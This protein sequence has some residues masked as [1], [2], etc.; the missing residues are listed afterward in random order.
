[1]TSQVESLLSDILDQP[2]ATLMEFDSFLIGEGAKQ[3]MDK[4]NNKCDSKIFQISGINTVEDLVDYS[5]PTT[6]TI[7]MQNDLATFAGQEINY[8]GSF[9]TLFFET[10]KSVLEQFGYI[11]NKS[12]Q[13]VGKPFREK[14]LVLTKDDKY[15]LS[16]LFDKGLFNYFVINSLG[17]LLALREMGFTE[18]K[19]ISVDNCAICQAMNGTIH[20][21]DTLVDTYNSGEFFIH[22]NLLCKFYPVIR[23]RSAYDGLANINIKSIKAESKTLINVPAEFEQDVSDLASFLNDI[24]KVEFADISKVSGKGTLAVKTGKTLFI[25]CDYVGVYSPMDYLNAWVDQEANAE[26]L[27]S[28]INDRITSEDVYYLNGK[29][30]VEVNGLYYDIVSKQIVR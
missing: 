24:D 21:V 9:E 12:K 20:K 23:K 3:F 19:F 1:M 26:K 4:C 25:H 28:T 27:L 13:L 10:K 22:P 16:Y 2:E 15:L 6:S 8:E 5:E 11:Q 7:T 29:K 17:Q 18:V 30:V 14:D